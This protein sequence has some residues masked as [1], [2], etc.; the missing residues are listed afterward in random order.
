MQIV[1]KKS[2]VK[3]YQKLQKANQNKIDNTLRLFEENPHDPQLKNHPLIGKLAGKRSISA[4][5]DLRIIFELEGNYMI[6]TML[7]VGTHNQ[8]Y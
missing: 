2:F 1:L 7:S 6:V 4:G 3:Q 5:F 8:V